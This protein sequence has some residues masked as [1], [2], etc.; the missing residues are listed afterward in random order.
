MIDIG[1]V[2][3][4]RDGSADEIR[5]GEIAIAVSEGEAFGLDDTMHGLDFH[6][7][8]AEIERLDQGEHLT[9][10]DGPGRGRCRAADMEF[11]RRARRPA[12]AI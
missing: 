2:E 6:R 9:D 1:A 7:G 3:K 10:G 5:V 12:R 4:A 8:L 11:T